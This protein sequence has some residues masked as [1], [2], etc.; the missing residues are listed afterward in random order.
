[1]AATSGQPA[2]DDPLLT[3]M[4]PHPLPEVTLEGHNFLANKRSHVENSDIDNASTVMA[5]TYNP[6]DFLQSRA[7]LA[8]P[9][10][11]RISWLLQGSTIRTAMLTVR[12]VNLQA[13]ATAPA[14][15]S[16]SPTAVSLPIEFASV[17]A[18]Q[19]L[20]PSSSEPSCREA[21]GQSRQYRCLPTISS[22]V[23]SSYPSRIRGRRAGFLRLQRQDV[24]VRRVGCRT[25]IEVHLRRRWYVTRE[26]AAVGARSVHER[27]ERGCHR[28]DVCTDVK[29]I[30]KV[31]S[32][33]DCKGRLAPLRRSMQS[34]FRQA[35]NF[36]IA[37]HEG[38][39]L[40]A[41]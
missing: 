12:C 33:D 35:C 10:R 25:R 17:S 28:P 16:I 40:E 30:S 18:L 34:L 4:L 6:I 11:S 23:S 38:E 7:P 20:P 9:S 26:V 1:M 13:L 5:S 2:S 8:I 24:V 29:Q 15:A 41:M 19:V 39:G 3:Q 27:M 36:M 37:Y 14:G 22:R 31:C 21:Q 32:A